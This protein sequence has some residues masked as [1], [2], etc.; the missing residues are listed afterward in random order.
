MKFQC[1]KNSTD[2]ANGYLTCHK[3]KNLYHIQCLYPMRKKNIALDS[4]W[5]CPEC[6]CKQP[7][8]AKN[9]NT[10]IRISSRP[11]DNVTLHRGGTCTTSPP[12]PIRTEHTLSAELVQNIVVTEVNKLRDEL[13]SLMCNLITDEL[14]PIRNEITTIKDSLNSFNHQVN[15]L[16]KRIEKVE[17]DLQTCL[18]ATS[19][20]DNL[21]S[22][23]ASFQ[24]ENNKV[25]LKPS[26]D[27]IAN[28]S[29][30]TPQMSYEDL[31]AELQ[32]RALRSKNIV[33]V[34]ISEENT[35]DTSKM[36]EHDKHRITNI[37]QTID[38]DCPMP[39]KHFRLGKQNLGKTRP[40]KVCFD[41][42]KTV[43]Y[44]LRNR[45]K[46]KTKNV[47][48]YSDQTLLQKQFLMDL[49]KEL[50]S[51]TENGEP[52]LIIKY[53]KGIPKI[54]KGNPKNLLS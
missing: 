34:G 46:L 42:D 28:R 47:R 1:C 20:I 49:R 36:Q 27:L 38:P 18:L 24:Q 9:D 44:L 45:T 10:P 2:G 31:A 17:T 6:S 25:S 19:D 12:S 15:N 48:I 7:K 39:L 37:L 26:V 35:S 54:I 43:K 3:C 29:L 8:Q 51:R 4:P 14:K 53:I 52:N 32:D 5:T 33:I 50:N 21:K 23:F 13:R 41:S 16:T 30:N 40:I 22:S 11:S